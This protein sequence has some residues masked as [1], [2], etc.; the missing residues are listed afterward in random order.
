[1]EQTKMLNI[2]STIKDP[3]YRYKMPKL[4]LTVQGS[5]GNT[6]TKLENIKDLATALTV[7]PDYPLK[8]IGKELGAQTDIK[9]DAY[10]INGNHTVDKLQ[11][12]IDKFIEKYV[13]CPKCKLPEI[14]IF[15]KKEKSEI[16]CKCR[17]CGT[18]SKLDDKHKFSNHIKNF[19]PKYDEE[20]DKTPVVEEGDSKQKS[21]QQAKTTID[22][23]IK[24]KIKTTIE[25]IAK[26]IDASNDVCE[27]QS[28]LENIINE[29]KLEMNLKYFVLI[30]GIFDK[31]IYQQLNQRLPI[32]K[33]ILNKEEEAQKQEATFHIVAALADLTSNRF[34]D[35]NRFVSSILYYFYLSDVITEEFWQKY[36][37]KNSLPSSNSPFLIRE[38]EVKF[39]ENSREFT[40]WI[41]N[42]PYEDEDGKIYGGIN[43]VKT[44]QEE[45]KVEIKSQPVEELDIDN[46]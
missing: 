19:P 12:F 15:L 5:G 27:L 38:I 40:H 20:L 45:V 31:N 1:M 9:N 32:I 16:R 29:S 8:F 21:Q 13:L 23:D 41:E 18:I 14:R 39:L 2:P 11:P 24:I 42:A 44:K 36:A 4:V 6:K 30:N 34:K 35:I 25:K 37:I 7:P 33:N 10:L 3:N 22:K 28:K 17:A 43:E 46:I 26:N